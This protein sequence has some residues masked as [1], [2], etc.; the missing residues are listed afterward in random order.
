MRAN[1][2]RLRRFGGAAVFAGLILSGCGDSS[3]ADDSTPDGGCEDLRTG[4]YP[5][6]RRWFLVG[7][8]IS[9]LELQQVRRPAIQHVRPEFADDL[10]MSLQ[11]F[12][13][14][15]DPLPVCRSGPE[16]SRASIACR[17]VGRLLTDN[18]AAME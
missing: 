4:K 17:S 9:A 8:L 1:A 18:Q 12:K 7:E 14:R 3:E 15:D 6:D 5:A 2:G 11:V 16:W 10:A 13:Q